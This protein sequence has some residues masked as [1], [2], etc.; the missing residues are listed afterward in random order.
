MEIRLAMPADAMAVARVHVR[1]WQAAYRNLMPAEYLEGLRPE[2]RAQKYEFGRD[3]PSKPTT[4]VAIDAGTVVGFSTVA[5]ARDIDAPGYGELCALY[6]DPD[7]FGE[8]IGLALMT[9]ACDGLRVSG[10]RDV[11]L[12]VFIGNERAAAFYRRH[13]WSADGT[14][15]RAVVW[16]IEV[17]EI[18]FRRP[19]TAG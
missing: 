15:R 9:K 18:R 4:I 12:W 10:F 14:H 5:P 8:G 17:G 11:L 6:V 7:R 19:L 2:D 3:D 16:G 13:R 1:S